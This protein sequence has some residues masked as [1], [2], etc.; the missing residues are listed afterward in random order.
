MSQ[1]PF[2][3]QAISRDLAV[4]LK[5]RTAGITIQEDLDADRF[6][7]LKAT[8][9]TSGKSVFIRI[10]TDA[11][12]STEDGH[13]DGLGLP[14]TVYAPHKCELAQEAAAS[15]DPASLNLRAQ[16]LAECAKLGMK[17]KVREGTG[18]QDAANWAAADAA[19]ATDVAEI[20]SHDIHP[21]TQQM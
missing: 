11:E 4:R 6:P 13:V 8:D 18:V 15:A 19:A 16:A 21:L 5:N 9:D 17:T 12:R 2:K 20:R 3:A 10:S 7:T 1:V 14:Q